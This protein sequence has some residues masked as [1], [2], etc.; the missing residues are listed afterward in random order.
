MTNADAVAAGH[1]FLTPNYKQ[2]PIALARGEG[3]YVWDADG[4]RYLDMLGGIATCAL[5]HCHPEV[6]AAVRAQLDLIWH[7]SNGVYNLPSLAL[8]ERLT[9]LSFGK[10]VF[11]CNS[12][13]EANEAAIKLARRFHFAAG[14]PERVEIVCAHGSFHGRTLGALAATGQPKYHQGIGP[15]PPGFVFVPHGDPAALRQAV[16]SQTA[17]VLIEAIQG[18]GGVRM[19]PKGYL[20]ELRKVCD[21]AGALWLADEV[22]TG[23]GRTGSL[24]AY[25]H[26]GVTPDV[27]TLAKALGNGLP[28]GAMVAS[29]KVGEALTPGTH[30]ST[31]GGNAVAC[32]AACAVLDIIERDNLLES[33]RHSGEYL[34]G[35]LHEV[36]RRLSG[37]LVEIRGRGL[38]WG[39]ELDKEAAP[40]IARCRE[41]GMIVNAAGERVVRFAPALLVEPAQLDEA[42]DILQRALA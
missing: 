37:R 22:Q 19:A 36:K 11:F 25:E 1:R 5:G 17:A 40:V 2:Q 6:K 32:A 23:M 26:E 29:E 16:G 24:W 9:R 39:V 4:R 35:R 41:L 20:A 18:E 14:H 31:F 8:A 28:V 21:A 13:T 3:L 15:L 10:R 38:L 30:A 34:A 33:C 42:A 12:G 7:T 27:M